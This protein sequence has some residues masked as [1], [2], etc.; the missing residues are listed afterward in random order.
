MKREG[1]HLLPGVESLLPAC[2]AVC[3][4]V[5]CGGCV[6][7]GQQINC[8]TE[9]KLVE[10]GVCGPSNDQRSRRAKSCGS[11]PATTNKRVCEF[12]GMVFEILMRFDKLIIHEN[13]L[14]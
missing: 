6:L 10:Q 12:C 2:N 9:I 14:C 8:Y 13:N 5:Y 4:I 1:S 7:A 11:T 3:K